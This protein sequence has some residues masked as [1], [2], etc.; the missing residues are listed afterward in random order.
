MSSTGMLSLRCPLL[1]RSSLLL[2]PRSSP[3]EDIS[4]VSNSSQPLARP[5]LVVLS[6]GLPCLFC[7]CVATPSDVIR[8]LLAAH[9][10]S[11]FLPPLAAPEGNISPDFRLSPPQPPPVHLQ[12]N[13]TA[14]TVKQKHLVELQIFQTA[15]LQSTVVPENKEGCP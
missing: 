6:P 7:L 1:R 12:D 9:N 4:D 10:L 15:E 2:S 11:L 3:C 14:N 5:D 13:F 8:T